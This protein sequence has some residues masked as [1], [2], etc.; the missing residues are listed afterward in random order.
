[1]NDPAPW[2]LMCPECRRRA[3]GARVGTRCPRDGRVLVE[4]A[5]LL[6][7]AGDD[8]ALGRLVG[9]RYAVVGLLGR[10]GF[11]DVYTAV[12]EPI[13][14]LVALKLMRPCHASDP[15]L[16]ERFAREARLLA[17]LTSRSAVTLLDFGAD[18]DGTPFMVLER[19]VGPT[20]E[21]AVRAEGPLAPARVA[22]LLREVLHALAEAHALGIVHRDLK[23]ANVML[24]RDAL[25]HETVKLL[26]FGVAR[27]LAAGEAGAE[28]AVV[29][30]PSYMAPEQIR[31]E[32][33]DG[34]ADLYALGCLA[35][36]LLTGQPPFVA[37]SPMELLLRQLEADPPTFDAGLGIP[38]GLQAVV[39]R[40]MAKRPEERYP[41]ATAMAAA[42]A[43]LSIGPGAAARVEVDLPAAPTLPLWCAPDDWPEAP[44]APPRRRRPVRSRAGAQPA[45]RSPA[46][47]ARRVPRRTRAGKS[48]RST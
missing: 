36:T 5:D 39:R 32:P 6:G 14:R 33:V 18:A 12:Q 46:R 47:V 43:A 31:G 8:P 11:G 3:P 28:G 21:Q 4:R 9:G 38:L 30:T 42:L 22:S 29:G 37:A 16:R 48:A 41:D 40:A 7:E 23:P 2:D 27:S 35:C 17:R 34:R 26:D 24:T 20:L 19:V 15:T 25:G 1:M 10:G 45:P 13:G 44:L